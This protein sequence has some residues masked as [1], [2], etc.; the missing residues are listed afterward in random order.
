MTKKFEF[1]C[2]EADFR[3]H[4]L[5]RLLHVEI[6]ISC[7]DSD[8]ADAEYAIEYIEDMTTLEEVTEDSLI[9]ADRAKL[10]RVCQ[11]YADELGHEAYSE[12]AQG[13]ADWAYDNWRDQQMEERG[14]G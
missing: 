12:Y 4:N 10:E 3:D 8:G 7:T 11:A 1:E 9:P 14:D 6:S 13:Q 2:N 5:C